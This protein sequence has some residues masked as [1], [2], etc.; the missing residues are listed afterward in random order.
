[1]PVKLGRGRPSTT[2][3]N[4]QDNIREAAKAAFDELGYD[5][6]SIRV[7]AERAKVDPKLVLHYFGS[8][9][10]LFAAVLQIPAESTR[11]I[12]VLGTTPKA[13]WGRAFADIFMQSDGKVNL[14]PMLGILRSASIDPKVAQTIREFYLR[15]SMGAALATAGLDNAEV[16]ASCMSPVL[17]GFV[18]ADQV[19]E[20]PGGGLTNAE[21]R[22]KLFEQLLQTI[23]TAPVE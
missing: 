6:A 7:I 11:A 3:T 22:R 10:E 16:R 15:S 1:M 18:F 19:L 5:K 2:T 17:A 20:I 14:P 12:A 8:K 4:R 9:A 23:L 21:M 13:D